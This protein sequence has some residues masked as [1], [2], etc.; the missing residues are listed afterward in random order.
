MQNDGRLTGCEDI[1]MTKTRVFIKKSNFDFYL[2][3]MY[4]ENYRNL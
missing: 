3:S 1:L 4:L 2:I